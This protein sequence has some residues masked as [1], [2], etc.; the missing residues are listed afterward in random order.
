MSVPFTVK[1]LYEYKSDYDDDL[2]FQPGQVITVT[3][4]EDD[5]WFLGNY[6]GKSGMFP[7]NFVEKYEPAVPVPERP[8]KKETPSASSASI[9]PKA[10]V[11]APVPQPAPIH[12]I[13]ESVAE[14]AAIEHTE[15]DIAPPFT[16]AETQPDSTATKVDTTHTH[17][18]PTSVP[19]PGALH[20]SRDDPYAVK[21]QFFGAGKSSYVPQVKPRDQLAVLHY[22]RH[23]VNPDA[24]IIKSTPTAGSH[25]EPEEPK[26]SLK[27]RIAMLQKRQQEEAEREAL[28]EQKRDERK[29]KA[30]EEKLARSSRES[31]AVS[32]HATGNSVRSE[33]AHELEAPVVHQEVGADE[34]EHEHDEPESIEASIIADFQEAQEHEAVTPDNDEEQEDE[35]D[36]DDED[37]RRKRLVERMAKISGGRN[38]FG[39]MGSTPFGGLPPKSTVPKT[40]VK[41][42]AAEKSISSEHTEKKQSVPIPEVPHAAPEVPHAAPEVPH[43]APAVPMPG[44]S[45]DESLVEEHEPTLYKTLAPEEDSS[46]PETEYAEDRRVGGRSADRRHG[47][48]ESTKN[49]RTV[50]SGSDLEDSKEDEMKIVKPPASE[51]NEI[52]GYEADEEISDR[53]ALSARN[54]QSGRPPV[55]S[56]PVPGAPEAPGKSDGLPI[57][58]DVVGAPASLGDVPSR[59]PPVPG[60][61][62]SHAE[63]PAQ[64]PPPIPQTAHITASYPS[65]QTAL[66]LP[67]RIPESEPPQMGNSGFAHESAPAPPVPEHAPPSHPKHGEPKL[68][69]PPPPTITAPRSV[70]PN[71]LPPS[72]PA[73]AAP[74]PIPIL[75]P[76]P[77]SDSSENDED[78]FRD[79]PL[80]EHPADDLKPVPKAQTYA[81][82]FASEMQPVAR[83]STAGS[84]SRTS[85][86][87]SRRSV[88]VE[89]RSSGRFETSQAAALAGT[90]KSELGKLYEQ[91]PWWSNNDVP[92]FLESKIGTDLIF[93]VDTHKIVKRAGRTV[94]YK[95]YYILFHD[96]SR[97]EIDLSYEENDPRGSVKVLLTQI[98]DP[99]SGRKDLLHKYAASIGK[100]ISVIALG[101]VGSKIYGSIANAVFKQVEKNQPTVLS[102]IGEKSYG[103]TVFKKGSG[104]EAQYLDDIRAGDIL[105]MK[106]AKFTSHKGL[107]GLTQ[108]SVTLGDGAEIYSAVIVEYDPKKEKFKVI[109]TD[110]SG[111]VKRESYKIGDMKSG[112]IRVF[113]PVDREYVGW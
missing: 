13:L 112:R 111:V 87:S 25:E 43:G 18:P 89:R 61:Q 68:P 54:D 53:G 2:T 79:A 11:L 70:P 60:P 45:E 50:L 34:E 20:L 29:K 67:P 64:M 55:P 105:C 36:E 62:S 3:E 84:L 93:E 82:S 80:L 76:V 22:A 97:I 73:R 17:K 90:L 49:E 104:L 99:P 113:R 41:K 101:L 28:A 63:R 58:S 106:N 74:P 96:L 69:P 85:Y 21:K 72:T 92:A 26:M 109:D 16:K 39:M 31:G 7:K 107:G 48:N 8:R 27:E 100:D 81:G 46:V 15:P 75:M 44:H 40:A 12:D 95:D 6:N 1:A 108:K 42:E 30:E 78:D 47:S 94:I 9:E 103:A 59:A 19:V 57:I 88:D 14:S 56:L 23:D 37:L 66:S 4:I 83:T 32:A 65:T 52:T 38:M 98:V 71:G 91:H 51:P 10:G 33:I 110:K 77:D 24:E 35:E 102:P 5:E 86:D